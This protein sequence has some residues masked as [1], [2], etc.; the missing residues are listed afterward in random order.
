[1]NKST[2]YVG[3]I[4][5]IPIRVD[6]SWFLIF[7]LITW[8]LAVSY[9]PAEFKGWPVAQYWI[10]GAATAILMFGCV[11][12]HEL[13]HSV[14][15]LHYKVP[16]RSITLFIFGGVAEID[17]EPPSAGAE[18]WIALAG[19]LVSFALALFFGLLQFLLTSVAPLLAVAEY[20]AYINGSLALFNLIPGFPLDGGRV[21]RAIVWGISHNFSKATL[22]AANVG[23]FIAFLFVLVGVWQVFNGD[24]S[25]G[26]WI[27]FIG[28]FLESAAA[29]QVHQQTIRDLFAG[30]HVSDAMRSDFIVVS[31]EET[32]EKLVN[33]QILGKGKRGLIVEQNGRV[34]GLL[35]LHAV[36]AI[37]RSDWPNTTAAQV[38]IP[39]DNIKWVHADQEIWAA[40]EEMDHEGVNQLPVMKD[41]QILGMLSRDDVIGMMRNLN[42]LGSN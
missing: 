9:F 35:T 4:F 22:I 6:Y 7:A 33:E 1:M 16:V 15:A 37:P 29:S 13:G 27:A 21:F 17:A 41:D 18:F 30:R 32:L 39:A 34:V 23:R 8:T 14:V 24:L 20:L 31:P 25:D 11:L 12:L 38:M 10:A 3:R 42:E 28:W 19:P 36:K 40:V 5:R 2:I 26:L